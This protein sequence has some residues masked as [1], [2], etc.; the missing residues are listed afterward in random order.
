MSHRVEHYDKYRTV[1]IRLKRFNGVEM[2]ANIIR[3]EI[4]L[5]VDK[6]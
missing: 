3:L 4:V 2:G 5:I 1:C 6:R